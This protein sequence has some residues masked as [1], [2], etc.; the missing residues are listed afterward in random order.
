MEREVFDSIVKQY[1]SSEIALRDDVLSSVNNYC[2]ELSE[3]LWQF[4]STQMLPEVLSMEWTPELQQ[5]Y[6]VFQRL[7][8][9][10]GYQRAG[11]TI[12]LQ[13][14]DKLQEQTQDQKQ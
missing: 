13:L 2:A 6:L 4:Y 14:K 5:E 8:N 9:T 12:L 3:E 7:I 11:Q 1:A 10:Q